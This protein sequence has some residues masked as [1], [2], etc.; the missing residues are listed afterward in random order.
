M[1]T[2]TLVG[3]PRGVSHTTVRDPQTGITFEPNVAVEVDDPTIGER[4][5]SLE[6][7]GYTFWVGNPG[8][9]APV[10]APVADA[11]VLS[12]PAAAEVTDAPPEVPATADVPPASTV[13]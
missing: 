9:L 13:Q 2:V 11:P 4:L 10:D 7:L 6:S 5:K 1:P 3:L 8:D 12:V